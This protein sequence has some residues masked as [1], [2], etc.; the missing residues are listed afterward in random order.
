MVAQDLGQRPGTVHALVAD[1]HGCIVVSRSGK[2]GDGDE[3]DHRKR[4]E[5]KA[6]ACRREA[7]P[8]R[9]SDDGDLCGF[10]DRSF[11]RAQAG[12]SWRVKERNA[13]TWSRVIE[14][15]P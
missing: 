14:E 15:W 13:S 2:Q 12:S 10:H 7:L 9:R 4:D 11:A 6:G 1:P 5:E 3:D 8:A